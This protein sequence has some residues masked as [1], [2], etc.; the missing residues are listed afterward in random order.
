[1][2]FRQ[3]ETFV[4][5]AELG[6]FR[7][8]ADKLN[9]TQPAISQR[10]AGLESS[11]GVRVFERG[12]R[13][14]RLTE[15]GQ[16][17]LAHAQHM[18]NLR[19]EMLRVAQQQ[20]AIRGTLRLGVAETLVHT[21]LHTLINDLHVRYPDLVIELHVDTTNVLRTQLHTHQ[22]DLAMLVDASHDPREYHVHL[23][24]YDLAWVA[25]PQLPLHGRQ[26]SAQELA[27]Y[28]IITYPAISLP[29]KR[30]HTALVQSGVKSPRMFGSASLST[31]IHMTKKAMGPSV[32]APALIQDDLNDG[33]LLLLDTPMPISPI[34]FYAAWMD[35]QNSYRERTV[36]TLASH[37]ARQSTE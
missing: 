36:A 34:S 10:I 2:D 23:C 30:V 28:P 8:A 31:I 21:W 25:S 19:T 33:T 13:G 32:L 20:R 1:M 16:E 3:I 37:I 5:I 14:I 12:T 24:D 7:A 15:K 26:V 4:W 18:L 35:S 22:I 17:L 9:A 11:L 27:A 29:Y 6:S